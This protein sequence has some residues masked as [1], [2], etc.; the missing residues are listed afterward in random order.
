MGR[1]RKPN[2]AFLRKEWPRSPYYSIRTACS[3]LRRKLPGPYYTIRT[4]FTTPSCAG[5]E[6]TRA[7]PS[8]VLMMAPFVRIFRLM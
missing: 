6:T 2:I 3:F 8:S 7:F 4:A 5:R 1:L